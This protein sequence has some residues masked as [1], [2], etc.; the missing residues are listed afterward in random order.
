MNR[1]KCD[2]YAKWT[3]TVALYPKT[4][5]PYYLALGIA[6]EIGELDAADPDHVED[7]AGDVLWYVAR[8]AKNVLKVEF[9]DLCADAERCARRGNFT[10]SISGSAANICA[11]EKK[12]IRDG[13]EWG[14]VMRTM[15]ETIAIDA[16]MHIIAHLIVILSNRGS[17]LYS[18]M[19]ANKAKLSKRLANH[20]IKGDGDNR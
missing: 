2:N 7:E 9:S 16:A 18:A 1:T 11:V 10:T 17:C 12:R 5:E 19:R 13:E 4:A 14:T 20:T 8:Y 15:K 3:D 6:N